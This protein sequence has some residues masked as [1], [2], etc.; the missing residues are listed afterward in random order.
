M[1]D[2]N[3][4]FEEA[5]DRLIVMDGATPRYY[6]TTV[7]LLASGSFILNQTASPQT[8]GFNVS[9]NGIVGGTFTVA[10]VAD[11]ATTVSIV[12]VLTTTAGVVVGSGLTVGT[13]ITV[14][15]LSS[16]RI[17]VVSTAG[18]ITQDNLYWD[19]TNDRL[20]LGSGASSPVAE[21][22]VT[23]ST[24]GGSVDLSILNSATSG[25]SNARISA[26]VPSTSTGDP[27]FLSN[28]S[29][30]LTWSFG[31]D[32]SDADAYVIS[33]AS[34]LGTSNRL[35]IASGGAVTIPG[36]LSVTGVV[37]AANG[38]TIGGQV[39]WVAGLTWDR[40]LRINGSGVLST[41]TEVGTGSHVLNNSPTIGSPTI[42]GTITGAAA[43]F[44]GAV[45]TGALTATTG[46]FALTD[47]I[48]NAFRAYQG[49][50]NYIQISTTNGAETALFGSNIATASTSIIGGAG[51]ELS[52]DGDILASG[53]FKLGESIRLDG[54]IAAGSLS[55]SAGS[56]TT[57]T[58]T[59]HNSYLFSNNMGSASYCTMTGPDSGRLMFI[60][61]AT[62]QQLYITNGPSSTNPIASGYN[63]ILIGNGSTWDVFSMAI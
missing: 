50:D 47:N 19:A 56:P 5:G 25:A 6:D 36:T 24:V 51:I 3:W 42:T 7:A 35:H 37:T 46:T 28:I 62:S 31:A 1:N 13:S 14:S 48:S 12:G 49:S 59:G 30:G 8:A 11:F 40:S 38:I 55:T 44:S 52:T 34:T 58:T 2:Q 21:I 61:N 29:G 16:G 9:G 43:N 17:P 33:E 27:Y 32:N 53:Y 18:L 63:A 41:N 60:K 57:I 39:N 45:S 26:Q 20:G 4:A 23:K 54:Y 15:G 10:G 22:D